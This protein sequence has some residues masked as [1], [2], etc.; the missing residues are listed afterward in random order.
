MIESNVAKSGNCL[1]IVDDVFMGGIKA[2]MA[3]QHVAPVPELGECID[4]PRDLWRILW[5]A[6]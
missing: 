3:C 4:R 2:A 1:I 5:D 6:Y